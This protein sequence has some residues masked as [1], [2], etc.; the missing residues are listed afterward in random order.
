MP[1]KKMM[2]EFAKGPCSPVLI[3]PGVLGSRL[4][5]EI[6]CK[7]MKKYNSKIFN[8]CGWNACNKFFW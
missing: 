6:D 3:L 4:M 1:L 5:V 8:Q 2:V 7:V